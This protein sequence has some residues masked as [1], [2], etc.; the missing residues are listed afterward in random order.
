MLILLANAHIPRLGVVCAD[1]L[2]CAS[3]TIFPPFPGYCGI[4]MRCESVTRPNPYLIGS[5]QWLR[6]TAAFG[7]HHHRTAITQTSFHPSAVE[8]HPT[9]SNVLRIEHKKHNA[10]HPIRI[11]LAMQTYIV[12]P[13]NSLV[14]WCHISIKAPAMAF[15]RNPLLW[16]QKLMRVFTVSL[17]R[18]WKHHVQIGCTRR[19]W[20]DLYLVLMHSKLRL[21]AFFAKK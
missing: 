6:L 15:I 11:W 10:R 18:M 20:P 1:H 21:V 16:H 2:T 3:L 8:Y 12:R 19:M 17:E 14:L 7:P 5:S 4:Y 9:P 13:N